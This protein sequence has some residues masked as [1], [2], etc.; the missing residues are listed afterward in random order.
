MAQARAL[1]PPPASPS[2]A[3]PAVLSSTGGSKGMSADA[4]RKWKEKLLIEAR[5]L[6]GGAVP[7]PEGP[8][9]TQGG[10]RPAHWAKAPVHVNSFAL[11]VCYLYVD[12]S[13]VAVL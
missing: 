7:L 4:E 5:L 3:N 6:N 2:T 1:P 13:H 9:M 8:L 11:H 12:D 10:P